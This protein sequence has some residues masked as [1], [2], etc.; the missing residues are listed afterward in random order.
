MTPA[1]AGALDAR[2][3]LYLDCARGCAALAVVVAHFGFFHIFDDAQIAAIPDFGREAVIAFFVL[4]GFVIAYSAE[5]KNVTARSYVVARA[6]RLYSVVLPVLALS[7]LLATFVRDVLQLRV[8]DGYELRRPWLYIPFHLA[9]LGD[10]WHFVERPPW[11]IPYW[12]LDYEAWYYVLFGVFHYLRGP[13]R[14]IAAGAVLA[15]VGPRLWLLLPVWLSGVALYRLHNRLTFGPAIARAGWLLSVV[16]IGLWG[17]LDPE[18]YL[19]GVAQGLWPFAGIRMGSADRVLADYAVM[20]L[21]LLNFACAR[22]AGFDGLL[23]VARPIRFLA[24]HTFTL[25]LSHGIVIGLWEAVLPVER[26]AAHQIGAIAVAIAVV[27]LALNP[28]TEV[29]QRVLRRVFDAAF[30]LGARGLGQKA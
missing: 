1:R 10:V 3:S 28:F 13:R 2:F 4:S 19:R 8:E 27:A 16:L 30:A 22:Q 11:L 5:H 29:V 21:V 7:F 15:F 12:S 18:P 17:W 6:A 25:Y 9:F 23:R 24:G 26:G 20:L 14:W